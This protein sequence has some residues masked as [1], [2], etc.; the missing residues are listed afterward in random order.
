MKT[1][2]TSCGTPVQQCI[3]YRVTFKHIIMS[4]FAMMI[5]E[6]AETTQPDAEA[7]KFYLLNSA[8]A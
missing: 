8:G 1:H 6:E 2:A 5:D 3:C 7:A 4:Q